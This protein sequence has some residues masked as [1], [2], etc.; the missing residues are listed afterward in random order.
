MT[1][2]KGWSQIG[3]PQGYETLEEVYVYLRQIAAQEKIEPGKLGYAINDGEWPLANDL[4]HVALVRHGVVTTQHVPKP[5]NSLCFREPR[6]GASASRH[7]PE[8]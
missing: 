8:L 3:R 1:T 2:L 5:K 6:H 4:W 7:R